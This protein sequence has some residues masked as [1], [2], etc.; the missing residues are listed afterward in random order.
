[1]TNERTDAVCVGETMALLVPDPPVAGAAA[2]TFRRE[3][4]GAE[5]NVAI[6]LA[7]AGRA[8]A[9]HGVLGTDGFG[10]HI[11]A[12]LAAEGV[13]CGARRHPELPT[14]MYLKEFS[15]GGTR[16]RYYR[17]GSAGATLAASDAD[18]VWRHTPRLVHTTGITS[19]LSDSARELTELLLH[20]KQPAPTVSFD[21]NYRPA[22][23]GRDHAQLLR[24]LARQADVVFCGLDEAHALWSA[25]SVDDVR[26]LLPEPSL[27]VVKHGAHGAYAC[28]RG[29]RWH[30]PA[31]EVDVVEPVGAGDAFAAGFLDGLLASATTE[32]CL[33]RGARLAGEVLQVDGDIPPRRVIQNDPATAG[34]SAPYERSWR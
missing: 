24:S 29:Q 4:G 18:A 34:P 27:L 26:E 11:A 33:A 2:E 15:P 23:H 22:L 5:S 6:H 14:G 12:R 31:P 1:M 10:D 25:D 3:L 19:A 32:E 21:V 17:R 13:H 16:V 20:S 8:A 28:S 9:W 7:R 30:Q